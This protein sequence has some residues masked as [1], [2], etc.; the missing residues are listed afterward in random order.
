MEKPDEKPQ[1]KPDHPH[2]A[3]P[4]QAKPDG[5]PPPKPDNGLPEQGETEEKILREKVAK[6][7]INPTTGKKYKKGEVPAGW[8]QPCE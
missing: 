6:R 8:N 5:G 3:P 1:G 2:G 7:P 4:G